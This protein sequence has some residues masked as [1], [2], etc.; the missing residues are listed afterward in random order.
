[1][2]F[3]YKEFSTVAR[4]SFYKKY[5]EFYEVGGRNPSPELEC[6]MGMSALDYICKL[7]GEI[8]DENHECLRDITTDVFD[9]IATKASEETTEKMD[10]MLVK[11]GLLIFLAEITK[12]IKRYY[13]FFNKEEEE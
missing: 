5:E 13:K 3:E 12:E 7:K 2:K 11:I 10:V 8:F 9:E 1:M 4:G 6:A